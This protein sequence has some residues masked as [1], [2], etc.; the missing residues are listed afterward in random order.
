MKKFTFFLLT[1]ST[2][3][4]GIDGFTIYN[5]ANIDKAKRA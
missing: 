1:F 4:F 2:F 5:T 3:L